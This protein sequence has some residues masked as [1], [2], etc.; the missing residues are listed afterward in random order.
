MVMCLTMFNTFR[1]HT[2]ERPY[3]C[4]CGKS[5][6]QASNYKNH[7][8]V[9]TGEMHKCNVCD[10]AA[11]QSKQMLKH[12]RKFGHFKESVKQPKTEDWTENC[13]YLCGHMQFLRIKLRNDWIHLTDELFHL[14]ESVQLMR[15][16]LLGTDCDITLSSIIR[17]ISLLRWIDRGISII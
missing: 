12:R 14:P 13:N 8:R 11:P 5:F 3:K 16:L 4:F 9:H 2:G 1:Q 6:A 15:W 17:R 7:Y 10:F